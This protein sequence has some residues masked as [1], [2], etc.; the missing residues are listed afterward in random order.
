MTCQA[1]PVIGSATAPERQP[2]KYPPIEWDGPRNG[3]D[4]RANSS[5][6]GSDGASGFFSSGRGV[7]SSE[8]GGVGSIKCFF[9]ATAGPA[10]ATIKTAS[11]HAATRI[12]NFL[13]VNGVIVRLFV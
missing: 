7:G 8:P 2:S 1:G 6:A 10:A 11:T 13:W 5:L 12:V 4:L 3:V 9:C